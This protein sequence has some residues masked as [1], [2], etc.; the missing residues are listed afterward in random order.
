MKANIAPFR[1]AAALLLAAIT[2]VPQTTFADDP[3]WKTDY[4]QAL[5][6]AAKQNKRVLLDFTGSDWCPYCIQMDK[7][8]LERPEFQKYASENLVLV[9]VDFPRKKQPSLPVISQNRELQKEYT[10]QGFP[11]YVLLNP[12]GKE[13]NRQ[14]GYMEG[15]P[16]AFVAWAQSKK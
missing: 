1:L 3:S 11:T 7:E 6:D 8:V 12:S 5:A 4:K 16:G 14:E 9:K 2:L 10:I 13:I 15:G